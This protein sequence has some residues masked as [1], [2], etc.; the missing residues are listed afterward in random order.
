MQA[1]ITVFKAEFHGNEPLERTFLDFSED[2]MQV[3]E[4]YTIA[5]KSGKLFQLLNFLRDNKINYGTHFNTA[6]PDILK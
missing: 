5:P 6:D 2:I 3:G 4:A 1:I